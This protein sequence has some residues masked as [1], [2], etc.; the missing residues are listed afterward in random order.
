VDTVDAVVDG[1]MNRLE[2]PPQ[3]NQGWTATRVWRILRSRGQ[4]RDISAAAETQG[5]TAP[6]LQR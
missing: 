6:S 5:E 2:Q 1:A 3:V 4:L